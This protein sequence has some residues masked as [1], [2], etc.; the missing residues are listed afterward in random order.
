MLFDKTDIIQQGALPVIKTAVAA[1]YSFLLH[2]ACDKKQKPPLIRVVLDKNSY[3]RLLQGRSI[4]DEL[5][6]SDV[7]K[8]MF[9][10]P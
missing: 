1:V 2:G 5:L 9:Q 6:Q 10:Q 3:R 4:F 8:R 7:G